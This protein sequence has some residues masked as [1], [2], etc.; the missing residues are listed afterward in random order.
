MSRRSTIGLGLGIGLGAAVLLAGGSSHA[1]ALGPSDSPSLPPVKYPNRRDEQALVWE[2]GKRVEG[3]GTLPGFAEYLLATAYTESRFN[4]DAGS[5]AINNAARG[6]FGLRPRSAMNYKNDLEHLQG[7]P[8]LLKDPAWSVALA[9][10]YARRLYPYRNDGQKMTFDAIRR[11]WAYP[12]KVADI[13]SSWS[14]AKLKKFRGALSAVGLS[15]SLATK[16]IPLG[17]WP[18]LPAVLSHLG[19][20]GA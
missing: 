14:K 7:D 16:Q 9:A 12:D 4:P 2:L 20:K 15:P 3:M 17:D 19:A 13:S 18:G 6:W 11:G 5:D 10:D 8:H 1:S